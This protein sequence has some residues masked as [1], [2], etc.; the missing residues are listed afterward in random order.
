MTMRGEKRTNAVGLKKV[1][2]GLV[3]SD[4]FADV[5]SLGGAATSLNNRGGS[6]GEGSQEDDEEG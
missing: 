2:N 5:C 6:V 3:D 4:G 1:A